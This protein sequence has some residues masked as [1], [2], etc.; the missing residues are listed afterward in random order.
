[1]AF[2]ALLIFASSA[3]AQDYSI[4]S[5]KPHD[6]KQEEK[7]DFEFYNGTYNICENE[8]KN[9]PVLVVNRGAQ[10]RYSMNAFG[11]N[12]IRLNVQEFSLPQG[13]NGIVLLELSPS[14][15]SEGHYIITASAA[16]GG[17]RK[18]LGL[19]VSVEKCYSLEL[20]LEAE[21]EKTCGG[22]KKQYRGQIINDGRQAIDAEL[23]ASGPN[24]I[25]LDSNEFSVDPKSMREFRLSADIPPNAKGIFNVAVSAT[26]KNAPW[27]NAEEKMPIEAVPKYDCYKADILAM[28][29]IPNHYSHEYVP[30][31]IVNSG[32]KQAEYGISL[33]APEWISAE[34]A[35]IALNPGELG[36]VNL[37]INPGANVN[38]GTYAIKLHARQNDNTYSKGMEI[39]LSRGR[40][41]KGLKSFFD[42][43]RYYIYAAL[44]A[45]AVLLVFSRK[46]SSSIK[47]SYR[48][49]KIKRSR[50]NALKEARK[51]RELKR[52]LKELQP[53][54][55]AEPKT[56]DIKKYSRIRIFLMLLT[57]LSGLLFSVYQFDFPVS[58]EF[59]K[60]NYAYLI[61]G[62][63]ISAFIIF[64]IEFYRPLFRLLKNLK[65]RK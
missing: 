58:K 63:L 5:G 55:K 8:K 56:N 32:I 26:A 60:G 62:I 17:S 7:I 47:T 20:K 57:A 12:W 48:N 37:N 3:Y 61:A 2:I 36:N 4:Y 51:A 41:L 44:L 6:F 29:K 35:K 38:E 25:S 54:D 39:A 23:K 11:T 9:I 27:V 31:K 16:S 42:F 59:A 65:K 46:I 24:W 15:D 10:S 53:T 40:L 14:K 22:A 43:Y 13:Q 21:D 18:D 1:M 45:T 19:D 30:V 34:P 33:E 50:L 49:Y 64:L 28:T 52:K